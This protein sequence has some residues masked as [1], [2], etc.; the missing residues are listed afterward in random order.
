MVFDTIIYTLFLHPDR[1]R[2]N[3]FALLIVKSHGS[4]ILFQFVLNSMKIPIDKNKKWVGNLHKSIDQLQ[5]EQKT[6]LMKQAGAHCANDLLKL[7]ESFLGRQIDS[8]NDLVSGWNILRDSR[9]LK[10]RWKF[11]KNI[12]HAIFDEC[13]CPLVRSGMIE[14]HPVQCLCSQGMMEHIFSRASKSAVKVEIK[15][16]IGSGDSVCEFIITF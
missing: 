12:V 7:C 16:A 13:G 15:R 6:L 2:D 11:E 3:A 8:I 9:N 5:E 1:Y 4:N 14:L 10:G